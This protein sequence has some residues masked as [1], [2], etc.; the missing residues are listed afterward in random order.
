[1]YTKI[2]IAKK[3]R[4]QYKNNMLSVRRCLGNG[5]SAT[6]VGNDNNT[7]KFSETSYHCAKS[8]Y[9]D[10]YYE[11][12]NGNVSVFND[13]F[14]ISC[15]IK[16]LNNFMPKIIK[17]TEKIMGE[18]CDKALLGAKQEVQEEEKTLNSIKEL[19]LN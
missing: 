13:G 15:L 4:I 7:F 12:S 3:L 18:E 19:K 17:E 1:M 16:A 5:E 9:L 2:E 11:C 6:N 10:A 14:Y 8:I